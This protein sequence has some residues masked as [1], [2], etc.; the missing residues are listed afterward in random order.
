MKLLAQ[1]DWLASNPVFYNE[2]T[3]NASHCIH[4]VIDYNDIEFD[5]EGF[6]NYLDFGYSVFQQTPIRHVK[7]LRHSSRLWLNDTGK[8]KLEYLDDPAEAWAWKTSSEAEVWKR[9]EATV[10]NWEERVD[11]EII[12]PTSGGFDSRLMNLFIRDK[13]RIRSFTYGISNPQ[14]ESYEVVHAK[15]LS[16][17]LG[18]KWEHIELGAFHQY[19]DDW[20]Q[21]Y[22]PATHAHGM[23]T[24][25]FNKEVEKRVAGDNPLLSGII[26]DAW[27]GGKK[28]QPIEGASDLTRL[29]LTHGMHADSRFSLLRSNQE[30]RQ[31]YY[32]QVKD[33]INEPFWRMVECMRFKIILLSYL[34][35]VPESFGFHPWSPFLDINIALSM[36]ALP[37]HRRV[38]RIWQVEYLKKRGVYLEGMHLKINPN[39]SLNYDA[40]RTYPLQP[41]DVRLL[42]EVIQPGYLEW[43]DQVIGT[44]PSPNRWLKRLLN[45]RKVGG[46]LRRAGVRPRDTFQQA[47]CAYLTLKPIENLL[48]RRGGS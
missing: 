40:T 45:V 39:N 32:Q 9:L 30:Q 7:F 1:T 34:F 14:S 25:E 43:I 5:P 37:A 3:G 16:E 11:G 18:T 20:D 33:K 4:G 31:A 41:L 28:I 44:M 24:I 12:I 42:R 36:L 47:Y 2:K 27:A 8:L 17:I 21:L 19:L 23:Y 26:G 15:K 29:G 10:V 38:G 6:N 22:G 48:M 35:R 46:L 13:S